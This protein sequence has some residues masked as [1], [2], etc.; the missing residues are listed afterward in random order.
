MNIGSVVLELFLYLRYMYLHFSRLETIKSGLRSDFKKT[1]P[2]HDL[3][4][5]TFIQQISKTPVKN[6]TGNTN[7]S[8][9]KKIVL[10]ASKLQ[11][12]PADYVINVNSLAAS[13]NLGTSKVILPKI[14]VS[15]SPANIYNRY[16]SGFSSSKCHCT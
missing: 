14:M 3:D 2:K 10:P 1:L 9:P 16:D 13:L 4:Y 15:R 7:K 5:E 6:P 12:L 8:P 11:P